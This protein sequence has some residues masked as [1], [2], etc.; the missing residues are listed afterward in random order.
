MKSMAEVYVATLLH[1]FLFRVERGHGGERLIP[2]PRFAFV[3]HIIKVLAVQ[4]APVFMLYGGYVVLN[5]LF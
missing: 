4:D 1:P 5:G 2:V 3:R